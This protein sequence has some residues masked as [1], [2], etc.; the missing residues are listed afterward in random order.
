MNE[1]DRLLFQLTQFSR[2]SVCPGEQKASS[3]V[4]PGLPFY[5]GNWHSNESI[6]T[7]TTLRGRR[8][9]K[10]IFTDRRSTGKKRK[11]QNSQR[12]EMDSCKNIPKHSGT[13][14]TVRR[15][16]ALEQEEK[17][18]VLYQHPHSW[19]RTVCKCLMETAIPGMS[20]GPALRDLKG[21]K[22][23]VQRGWTERSCHSA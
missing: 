20:T 18:T 10:K 7:P 3:G 8:G 22:R 4:A 19:L 5:L 1:H 12:K 16:M 14:G 13:G 21:L 2:F 11:K 23:A 6:N 9:W 15:V 17:R